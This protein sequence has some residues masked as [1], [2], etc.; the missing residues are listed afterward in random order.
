MEK[1]KNIEGFDYVI[2][3]YGRV[4]HIRFKKCLND[5]LS[6]G[7]YNRVSLYKDGIQK[8][9]LVHR[10][11]AN[12]FIT[13][14]DN[15]PQVNHI[16]GD[17]LNNNIENL[18][19]STASENQIHRCDILKKGVRPISVEKDGVIFNFNSLAEAS[20]NLCIDG[21]NLSRLLNGKRNI[22]R[23]YKKIN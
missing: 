21:G 17:K 16:D 11:V 5:R 7:G 23:G 12:A 18:E 19:W 9:Y 22:V 10:L 20:R 14:N 8:N 3:S 15:K 1:W 6:N 2:S 13:N 4:R